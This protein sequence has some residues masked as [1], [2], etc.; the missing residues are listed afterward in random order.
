MSAPTTTRPVRTPDDVAALGT[1][2]GVWAHPDDEL[3]LSGGVLAAAV[4]AGR[5]VVVVTA[6]RGEHGTDDPG[7]WSPARLAAERSR[8]ITASLSALDPVR[9]RI[10]HR[11]LGDASGR[12]HRDGALVADPG[13][14]TVDELA[15]IVA[16]I[17]PDTVVTFGPDGITGHRDHRA[18]SAWTDRALRRVPAAPRLLHAAVTEAWVRRF[19]EFAEPMDGAGDAFVPCRDAELAVALELDEDLLDRKLAALR[20]Q[21]TQTAGLEAAVGAD[22]Y[23]ASIAGEYFRPAATLF[24]GS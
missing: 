1:V 24:D 18:V 11:F 3:Y 12:C 5:R 21:A 8:E 19:A 22:R 9:R 16:E 13:E 10:E 14:D 23:R 20:A 17:A 7:R 15:A 2:L 6:T 4:A